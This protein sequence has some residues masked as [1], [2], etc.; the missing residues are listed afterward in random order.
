MRISDR[1]LSDNIRTDLQNSLQSLSTLQTELATGKRINLPSD[2]P[3]GTATVMRLSA[4]IA[5]DN[6][7]QRVGQ[8]AIGRLNAADA[9]LGSLDDILQRARE[10]AVQGGTAT[11]SPA[12]EQNIAAEVNQL[13]NQAIQLG[14]TNFGGVYIFGGTQTTTAPFTAVG[15]QTP[16]SATYNGNAT[17]I[18]LMLG[19]GASVQVDAPGSQAIAPAIT[20]L[21]ALRDGLNSGTPQQASS[22]A[23][24]QI[25]NALDNVQ[26]Q[27]GTIGART[28]GLTTLL[29][30]IGDET[31][32]LTGM[33]S[34]LAD[35]DITDVTV[36]LQSAQNV[37]QAALGTAAKVIVPSLAEFLH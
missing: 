29:A 9:A 27:R 4:D 35:V 26:T 30:Q 34:N 5:N 17:P 7:A 16:T 20:A 11:I 32:N 13:A 21:I 33:Q 8:N 23:I 22:A 19:A 18:N 15:G 36:R 3:A 25:D 14:N 2:D 28:N 31:T 12:D 24:G 37:Y 6:E 10:L 1:M